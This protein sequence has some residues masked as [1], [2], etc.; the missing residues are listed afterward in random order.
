MELIRA[1]ARSFLALALLALVGCKKVGGLSSSSD[2][3]KIDQVTRAPIDDDIN[4]GGLNDNEDETSSNPNSE[5][6]EG[7]IV[8]S[9]ACEQDNSCPSHRFEPW[10]LWTA[11][12]LRTANTDL[13]F[14]DQSSYFSQLELTWDRGET[15]ELDRITSVYV[16]GVGAYLTVAGVGD[17]YMP[18]REAVMQGHSV[19]QLGRFSIQS[20]SVNSWWLTMR[21]SRWVTPIKAAVDLCLHTYQVAPYCHT[22]YLEVSEDFV[23]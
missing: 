22:L 17:K 3:D 10:R 19:W 9:Y 14:T 16:T 2:G 23:L 6:N 7:S 12:S 20:N 1:R 21:N 13:D 11:G 15:Y 4:D 8:A 18:L 5:D